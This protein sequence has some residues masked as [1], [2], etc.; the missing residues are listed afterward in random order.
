VFPQLA[1]E[2]LFNLAS[3][4]RMI[5]GTAVLAGNETF[6]RKLQ[7]FRIKYLVFVK[8]DPA[9][10]ARFSVVRFDPSGAYTKENFVP[11]HVDAFDRE[12]KEKFFDKVAASLKKL[13]QPP[14]VP[15]FPVIVTC[16]VDEVGSTAQQ[17]WKM[18][19]LKILIPKK[20]A[21]KLYR[22][23]P[24]FKTPYPVRFAENC[25]FKGADRSAYASQY[26]DRWF[27][28]T[29]VISLRGMKIHVAI[30]FVHAAMTPWPVEWTGEIGRV[31]IYR[32]HEEIAAT[33]AKEWDDYLDSVRPQRGDL[34]PTRNPT[35][36][37]L[38]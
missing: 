35:S 15:E 9:A 29:G 36:G 12:S 5:T 32:L 21:A 2:G 34:P 3:V 33:I 28:W 27:A 1:S 10:G 13:S 23:K 30:D 8:A 19:E 17:G 22:E 37:A 25:P 38:R 24:H 4:R 7:T 26:E 6:A 18:N 20:L 16:F 11:G 31:D 14:A